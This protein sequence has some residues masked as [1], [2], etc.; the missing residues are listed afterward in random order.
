VQDKG[1][2]Q[3]ITFKERDEANAADR[4][5]QMTGGRMGPPLGQPKPNGQVKAQLQH[6]G[7]EGRGIHRPRPGLYEERYRERVLRQ[8]SQRAQKLGMKLFATEQLELRRPDH[9][10]VRS[11]SRTP[12]KS[13]WIEL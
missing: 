13:A 8:L 7:L 4:I 1:A 12:A 11:S 10:P 9:G 6:L 2:A 3:G 5:Y